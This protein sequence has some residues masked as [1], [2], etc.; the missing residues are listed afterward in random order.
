[1]SDYTDEQEFEPRRREPKPNSKWDVVLR[2]G[3]LMVPN[4][5]LRINQFLGSKTTSYSIGNVYSSR[6][7]KLLPRCVH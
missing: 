6:Y 4:L 7:N 5:L 3:F 1:M 2:L